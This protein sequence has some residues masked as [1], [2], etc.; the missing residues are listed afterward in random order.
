MNI[1][2]L[3]S[4]NYRAKKCLDLTRKK[5]A[6][7]RII[8]IIIENPW[9]SINILFDEAYI[10]IIILYLVSIKCVNYVL[11]HVFITA[12][13]ERI[14]AKKQDG[15]HAKKIKCEKIRH[16]FWGWLYKNNSKLLVCTEVCN[17]RLLELWWWQNISTRR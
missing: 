11:F 5:R 8:L 3:W 12:K 2:E 16:C 13:Y 17:L 4:Y 6:T 14:A 9:N 15:M 7:Q 1:A 10:F